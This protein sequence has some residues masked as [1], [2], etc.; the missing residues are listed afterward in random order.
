MGTVLYIC[1][2]HGPPRPGV[3]NSNLVAGK[4][5]ISGLIAKGQNW[6][7]LTHSKGVLTKGISQKKQN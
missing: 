1:Y 7:I 6:C 2:L 4:E 3:H 5:N